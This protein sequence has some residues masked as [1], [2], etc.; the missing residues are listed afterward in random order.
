MANGYPNT[1]NRDPHSGLVEGS[2]VIAFIVWNLDASPIMEIT[3][4]V[5]CLTRREILMNGKIKM[6]ELLHQIWFH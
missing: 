2:N 1:S 3:I 5:L 6:W 4:L